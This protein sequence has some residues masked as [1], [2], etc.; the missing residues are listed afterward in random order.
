MSYQIPQRA[1]TM[2]NELPDLDDLENGVGDVQSFPSHGSGLPQ[3]IIRQGHHINPDAGMMNGNNYGQDGYGRPVGTSQYGSLSRPPQEMR[4]Q[5]MR[6]QEMIKQDPMPQ[7]P[8]ISCIEI[9]RHIM[10]CPICSRFYKNDNTMY[11]IAIVVLAIV[12]LLLL[13]RVLN[14]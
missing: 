3:G 9:S 14:V 10:D 12:C 1:V 8:P 2:I 13:K 5:E 11:I 7:Y 4:P 6:P